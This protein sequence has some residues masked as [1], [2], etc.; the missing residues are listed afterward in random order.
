MVVTMMDT[1]GSFANISATANTFG[2]NSAIQHVIII[3][4]ENKGYFQ[5][6]GSSNA[7]YQNDLLK[8]CFCFKILRENSNSLANMINLQATATPPLVAK[9]SPTPN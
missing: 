8:I 7:P 5:I 4:M 2:S 3:I 9:V 6:I 1:T